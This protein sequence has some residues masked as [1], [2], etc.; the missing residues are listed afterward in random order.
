MHGLAIR[1]GSRQNAS[2]MD[3]SQTQWIF[4]LLAAW[5]VGAAK[6]GFAGVGLIP[7]FVMAE[8]FGKS[9]VGI[10]LPMLVVADISVFHGYRK[11]GSWKPV[12]KLLPP[13]LVGIVVGVF[14]LRELPEDWARPV[15]GGLILFMVILGG[16]G[17]INGAFIGAGF[18]LLFPVV[19]NTLGNAW[20]H[21]M[22]DATIISAIEQVVFGALIILFLIY[23]PLGM[24]K[25]WEN[26]KQ[27]LGAR[28][29]V[30]EAGPR[31]QETP[32]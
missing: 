14:V 19:L 30:V 2:G 8:V 4:L 29:P 15:I 5:C 16:L 7:V 31:K 20:F 22:I 10:L 18:I 28:K 13:A 26:L 27:R 11:H 25:L 23:E 32:G 17:T 3:L 24:A 9:S 21:G 1:V 6:A 12:W